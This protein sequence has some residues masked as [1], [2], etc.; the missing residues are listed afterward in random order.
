MMTE[1]PFL[2]S[3]VIPTKDRYKYLKKLI[4][5]IDSYN[6]NELELIIQDNSFD[7]SEIIQFLNLKP[8]TY[9]KYFYC[10]D[11]ISMT[12]NVDLAIHNS[13]GEYVCLLGDDDGFLPNIVNCVKWMKSNNIDALQ[14]A[15]TIYNWPD[16]FDFEGKDTNGELHLDN[17]SNEINE[18]DCIKS[19]QQLSNRG[20]RHIYTIPKVYQ[21]IVKRSCLDEVYKIGE[22]YSPGPSPDMATAVALSFVVKKFITINLPVIIVGQSVH[23]GGGE[24]LLK[25]GVKNIDDVPFLPNGA[26]NKWSN[27][28][29][30]VWC[31]Q[32]VWPES[33]IKAIEYMNKE[34]DIKINYEFILAWFIETHPE[35]KNMALNLSRNKVILYIYLIYYRFLAPIIYSIRRLIIF[36]K[37]NNN[38][39]ENNDNLVSDISDIEQASNYLVKRYSK[40]IMFD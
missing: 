39:I 13:S 10:K 22:T 8:R 26:K 33:A 24:R 19:L 25:G 23:V 16:F 2:L 7:N 21:G 17:F 14:T 30:K 5:L 4:S 27:R 6:L 28:I 31:S 3:V 1:N 38:R 36:F 20:F 15:V 11:S 35:E 32:T 12:E 34:K 18:I 40:I 29:P 9:L 37:F